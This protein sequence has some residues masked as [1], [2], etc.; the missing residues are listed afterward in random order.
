MRAYTAGNASP[1]QGN[2]MALTTPAELLA[3]HNAIVEACT[4]VTQAR[5][6]LILGMAAG[7]EAFKE[8]LAI[9]Q[10]LSKLQKRLGKLR[11]R[12]GLSNARFLE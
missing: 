12:T 1:A 6:E 2:A 5:H 9:A 11:D 4:H 8:T 10:A 3:Q 7:S